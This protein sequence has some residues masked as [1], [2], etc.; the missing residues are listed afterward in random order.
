[1]LGQVIEL[2]AGKP[3][4]ELLAERICRPL[5]LDHTYVDPQALACRVPPGAGRVLSSA[6]DLLKLASVCLGF[7]TSPLSPIL[8]HEYATHGGGNSSYLVLDPVRRRAVVHLARSENGNYFVVRL[9]LNRLILNQSPRPPDTTNIDR[10]ICER[11][12]GEYLSEN[13]STWTVHREGNRLLVQKPWAP[14]CEVFPQSETTF[15]SQMRGLGATFV[16]ERP[17]HATQ[18]LLRDLDSNWRFRGAKISPHAPT[19]G[20]A[21]KIDPDSAEDYTGQYHDR[22]GHVLIIQPQGGQF[23]VQTGAENSGDLDAEN[24]IPGSENVFFSL[25]GPVA[26]TFVRDSSGKVTGV[27][28]HVYENHIRYAKFGPAPA[29]VAEA[30]SDRFIGVWEG[31]LVIPEQS[32]IQMVINISKSK[33][34]YQASFDV[35]AKFLKDLPFKTFVFPGPSSLF[36]A[37]PADDGRATFRATL[38][39]AATEMSGTWKE[40]QASFAVTFKR[41]T[42]QP[43]KTERIK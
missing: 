17:G 29:G 3:Y 2:K 6:N 22:D 4:R 1:M 26:L 39:D 38:N 25:T 15:L 23:S 35:P 43:P 24:L 7:T 19:P 18:L 34:S 32:N 42:G 28:R 37:C 27:I 11:Y 8:R 9:N 33:G 36:L 40:G 31:A 30:D 12:V 14:S 21:F 5:G 10:K 41:N 20:V 16:P 13:N